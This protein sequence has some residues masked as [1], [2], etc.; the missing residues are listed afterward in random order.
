PGRDLYPLLTSDQ[1][2]A[3][4]RTREANAGQTG[5][6]AMRLDG[7]SAMSGRMLAQALAD[8]GLT[9]ERGG[10]DEPLTVLSGQPFFGPVTEV[11]WRQPTM[12][13]LRDS[14]TGEAD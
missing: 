14:C 9:L 7:L 3:G 13:A 1:V 11:S 6:I 5:L 12:I 10:P 8:R 4:Q 2:G